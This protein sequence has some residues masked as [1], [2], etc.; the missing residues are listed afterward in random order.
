M[1]SNPDA[2]LQRRR[3]VRGG[4]HFSTNNLNCSVFSGGLY[5]RIGLAYWIQTRTTPSADYTGS[6]SGNTYR[7]YRVIVTTGDPSM[8]INASG[9]NGL[10]IS[11]YYADR[12]Q[13]GVFFDHVSRNNVIPVSDIRHD[14]RSVVGIGVEHRR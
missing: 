5:K 1:D 10:F 3:V 4:V 14:L 2:V 12:I 9:I 8:L 13:T 7:Y 11:G 6:I